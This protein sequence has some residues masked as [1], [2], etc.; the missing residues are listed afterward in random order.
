MTDEQPTIR[1]AEI[2]DYSACLPFFK[3]LYHGDIGT[4]F[5]LVF[6]C[7]VK[8]GTILLAE[9]SGRLL[10]ILVGSYS[11]DIDWE[12]R[13]AKIDAVIVDENHRMK[14]IGKKLVESF[15]SAAR[16]QNCKAIKS[17]V[18]VANVISQKF[19]EELGFS[20]ADTY[21]YFSEL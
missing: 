6:K 4:D 10:G 18:N 15:L 9:A 16:K 11:L 2:A 7:Y 14:G 20:R 1:S 13:I 19:H 21:E 5:K 3:L 17:R 12:G 8:E